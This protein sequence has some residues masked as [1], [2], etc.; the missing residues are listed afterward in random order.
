M[1]NKRIRI[2]LI[3]FLVINL[4][5]LFI[6]IGVNIKGKKK[7]ELLNNEIE[8]RENEL[9]SKGKVGFKDIKILYQNYKG[10]IAKTDISNR[11]EVVVNQYFKILF[12]NVIEKNKDI[13]EYFNQNKRSIKNRFGITDVED[14]KKLIR[15]I[16][17]LNCSVSEYN[18][19]EVLED[20]FIQQG[21]YTKC[22][23]I[24]TY[25]NKQEIKFDLYI[26][27]TISEE[28]LEYIFIPKE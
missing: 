28:E 4:I 27:N 26:R 23:L 9:K 8:Y 3:V 15:Q 1:N 16:Q 20:S 18:S 19:Y 13:T 6:M 21:D 14:F 22:I 10:E 17:K 24:Y 2:I 12:K 7:T 25:S 5:I 11:I